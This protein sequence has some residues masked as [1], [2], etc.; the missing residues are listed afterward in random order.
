MI[1]TSAENHLPPV[2][3]PTLYIIYP[4]TGG[5]IIVMQHYQKAYGMVVHQSGSQY[6]IGE[7]VPKGTLAEAKPWYGTVTLKSCD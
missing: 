6:K 7:Y 3:T 2:P 1:K 4:T 5:E